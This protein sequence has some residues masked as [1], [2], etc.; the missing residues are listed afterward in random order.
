MTVRMETTGAAYSLERVVVPRRRVAHL[1]YREPVDDARSLVIH[2]HW[3]VAACTLP[4]AAQ[5]P[6]HQQTHGHHCD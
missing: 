6:E 1:A 5:P 4:T 3:L 2:N